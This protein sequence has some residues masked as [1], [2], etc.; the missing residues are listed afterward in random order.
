MFALLT[1][2]DRVVVVTWVIRQIRSQAGRAA[3]AAT[4][5]CLLLMLLLLLLTCLRV[6]FSNLLEKLFKTGCSRTWRHFLP[7]FWNCIKSNRLY[8]SQVGQRGG[9][10]IGD[11][12][13]PS[14]QW[15][16]QLDLLFADARPILSLGGSGLLFFFVI[17][18][19][20]LIS[21]IATKRGQEEVAQMQTPDAGHDEAGSVGGMKRTWSTRQRLWNE[22][23]LI[24]QWERVN[25]LKWND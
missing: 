22:A 6:S 14:Y 20:N 7:K 24:S 19:T 13:L 18:A 9:G 21:A 4:G 11:W 16:C 12:G 15:T 23:K 17:I 1:D 8:L 25:L 5:C 3:V 10:W 2:R